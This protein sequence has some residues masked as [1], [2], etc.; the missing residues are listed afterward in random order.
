MNSEHLDREVDR[1]E[2]EKFKYPDFYVESKSVN[3]SVN[4]SE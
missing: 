4:R 3:K 2:G 1:M